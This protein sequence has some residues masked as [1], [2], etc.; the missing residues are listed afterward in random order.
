MKMVIDPI[1]IKCTSLMFN[2]VPLNPLNEMCGVIFM[3]P[4]F[5]KI[6]TI[7]FATIPQQLL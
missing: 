5:P 3:Y 7:Q 2:L 6:D 1:Q 4:C